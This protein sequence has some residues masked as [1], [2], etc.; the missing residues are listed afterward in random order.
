EA[1]DR[2]VHID[3]GLPLDEFPYQDPADRQ[4]LIFAVGRLVEKKG[5]EFLLR[6]CAALRDEGLDFRCQIAGGGT[7]MAS[8]R[9]LVGELE[10]DNHVALMGPQPQG[11]IRRK[12]HEAAV[13]AA[14]CIVAEDQDR[15][16]LPTILLE[17]MAMG[18]PCV[19]TDVTGIP[20][21]LDHELTGLA[22]GQRDVE[23]L[24]LACRKLLEDSAL[25]VR[26]A[27]NA[28]AQIESRFDIRKNA[29]RIRDMVENI[30][31]G[32]ATTP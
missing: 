12:L 22:V 2:L 13:L 11:V 9:T 24:A 28:R 8:L 21:I 19:S 14:P 26:L 25:R 6:A 3:N 7:L 32:A 18:T 27:R 30:R 23:G 15:D 16:G 5:F 4:P 20:E 10:L 17:A 31:Q 29:G 1:S